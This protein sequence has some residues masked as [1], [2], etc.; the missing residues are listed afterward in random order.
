[1]T[2][3]IRDGKAVCVYDDDLHTVLRRIGACRIRRAS[4]VEYDHARG[5]WMADLSPTIRGCVL[6]P[7][8]CRTDALAAERARLEVALKG[9]EYGIQAGRAA[10]SVAGDLAAAGPLP[11]REDG[12]LHQ[13]SG[14]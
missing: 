8:A 12:V 13:A 6:G 2:I 11:D 9:G 7:Y 1:M 14:A 5:G 3:V 10:A 4:T